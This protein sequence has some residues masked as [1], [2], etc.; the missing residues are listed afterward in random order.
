MRGTVAIYLRIRSRCHANSTKRR[1]HDEC[2]VHQD[3]D[4][5]WTRTRATEKHQTHKNHNQ[6]TALSP[7]SHAVTPDN[8]LSTPVDLISFLKPWRENSLWSYRRGYCGQDQKDKT[9]SLFG[10]LKI[11]MCSHDDNVGLETFVVV[12]WNWKECGL[13]RGSDGSRCQNSLDCKDLHAA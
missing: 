3:W 7:C 4:W 5:H 8:P 12:I 10:K 6:A 9:C 1:Q 11:D 2:E 13:W